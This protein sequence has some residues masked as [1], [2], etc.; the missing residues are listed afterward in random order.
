MIVPEL[1]PLINTPNSFIKF[2]SASS[3]SSK[4]QYLA[5]R[6]IRD[7]NGVQK[8]FLCKGKLEVQSRD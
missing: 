3:I 1:L 8:E 5:S 7:E 4:A 2:L 6:V